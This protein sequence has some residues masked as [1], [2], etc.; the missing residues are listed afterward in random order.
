MEKIAA[1][2]AQMIH[3]QE[4]ELKDSACQREGML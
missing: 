3:W 1:V 4:K 2:I